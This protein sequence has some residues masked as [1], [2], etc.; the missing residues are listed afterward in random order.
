MQRHLPVLM[1]LLSLAL[2]PSELPSHA[3]ALPRTCGVAEQGEAA[4]GGEAGN[5][6]ASAGIAH[7]CDAREAGMPGKEGGAGDDEGGD[8]EAV[9]SDYKEYLDTLD[10]A[11][12][13]MEAGEWA[14]AEELFSRVAHVGEG[15]GSADSTAECAGASGGKGELAVRERMLQGRGWARTLMQSYALAERDL[16]EGVRRF[17]GNVRMWEC[18]GSLHFDMGLMP[19]VGWGA[20]YVC[21]FL[22]AR[23]SAACDSERIRRLL[24]SARAAPQPHRCSPMARQAAPFNFS[25]THPSH[26]HPP[27]FPPSPRPPLQ[28]AVLPVTLNHIPPGPPSHSLLAR[29]AAHRL[30]RHPE[31]IADLRAVLRAEP[32]DSFLLKTVALSYTCMGQ[33][34][35]SLAVWQEA[36]ERHAGMAEMWEEKGSVHRILGEDAPAMLCLLTALRLRS[37]LAA[38]RNI[39]ALRRGL[40][41]Y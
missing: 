37:S 17:P 8:S 34:R 25:L 40:G 19:Q 9:E 31:A 27:L 7:V 30:R 29:L 28:H 35:E 20:T 6:G 24:T 4:A 32:M 10:E 38:Y 12:R 1:L 36:V 11:E 22:C 21:V 16:R 5:S 23:G 33:Y 2:L 3:S 26:H 18:L 39:V 41:D 14:Q 15:R 13:Q